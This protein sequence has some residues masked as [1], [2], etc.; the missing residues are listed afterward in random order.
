[1]ISP[2]LIYTT[3]KTLEDLTNAATG[4][5]SLKNSVRLGFGKFVDKVQSPM[6]QMTPYK[7][8]LF[9]RWKSCAQYIIITQKVKIGGGICSCWW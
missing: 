8:V 7:Y 5:D 2:L 1:M 6:T 4:D 3:V 9:N